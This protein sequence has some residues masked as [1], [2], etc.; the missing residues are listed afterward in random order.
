MATRN[1][2]HIKQ[3]VSSQQSLARGA[4]LVESV[5]PQAV[6][7]IALGPLASDETRRTVARAESKP[8]ALALLLMAPEFQRR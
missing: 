2:E 5:D 4:T 1:V 7:E 6:M 8:Q 3:I